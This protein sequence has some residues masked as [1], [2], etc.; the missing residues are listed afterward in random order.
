M[1]KGYRCEL[2]MDTL[3]NV[4]YCLD[5]RALSLGPIYYEYGSMVIT[6]NSSNSA[7]DAYETLKNRVYEDKNLLGKGKKYIP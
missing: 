7:V 5:E 6:F 3:N 4:L 2:S 1:F